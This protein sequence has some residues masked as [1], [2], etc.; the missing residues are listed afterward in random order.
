MVT[1]MAFSIKTPSMMGLIADLS[2]RNILLNLIML[3]GII[4]N[5]LILRVIKT[6]A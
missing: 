3:S 6:N 5:V 4:L 1:L 2:I